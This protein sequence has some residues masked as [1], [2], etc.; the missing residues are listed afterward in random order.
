MADLT[1]AGGGE[2]FK[3]LCTG[4]SIVFQER[5]A[6]SLLNSAKH[7]ETNTDVPQSHSIKQEKQHYQTLH[8][9]KITSVPRPDIDT[10]EKL[11]YRTISLIAIDT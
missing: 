1:Y 11:N 10:R 9:A 4:N 7:S 3:Q 5:R 6:V 8:Q 2:Q